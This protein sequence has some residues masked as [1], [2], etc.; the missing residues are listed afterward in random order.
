MFGF[1]KFIDYTYKFYWV[2]TFLDYHIYSKIILLVK[3]KL[4]VQKN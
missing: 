2:V 3:Y 4:T 1:N